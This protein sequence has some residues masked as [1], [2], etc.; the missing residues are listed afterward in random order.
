MTKKHFIALAAIIKSEIDSANKI[1]SNYEAVPAIV[2]AE[3]IAFEFA[4]YAGKQ[5]S[6]FNRDLFLAACGV[7]GYVRS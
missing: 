6:R 1:A 7:A 4:T 3:S 2:A 5:N